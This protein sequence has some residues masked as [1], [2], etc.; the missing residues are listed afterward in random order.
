MRGRSRLSR[1]ARGNEADD[2]QAKPQEGAP[3]TELAPPITTTSNAQRS[4]PLRL[5]FPDI[6]LP[7][8]TLSRLSK[9]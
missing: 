4:N 7:C 9:A 2:G 5:P 3:T 6:S 1:Y 8:M